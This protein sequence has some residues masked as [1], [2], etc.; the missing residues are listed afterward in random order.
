[1]EFLLFPPY[2]SPCT[3][4]DIFRSGA[5]EIGQVLVELFVWEEPFSESVD[6]CLMVVK[7]N[8]DLLLVEVSDVV[9]K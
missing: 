6:R 5:I 3:S 2:F 8:G 7:W 4:Q 1:M 9:S